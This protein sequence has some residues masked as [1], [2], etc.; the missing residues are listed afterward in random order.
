MCQPINFPQTI[1]AFVGLAY[2]KI[3]SFV[4]KFL[5]RRMSITF[6]HPLLPHQD[7][8]M[9]SKLMNGRSTGKPKGTWNGG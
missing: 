2:K 3:E 4:S 5:Y 9:R 8:L 6:H 1:K 7:N